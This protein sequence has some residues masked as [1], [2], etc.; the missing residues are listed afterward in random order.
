M[1]S[2]RLS[3]ISP[4]HFF[5]PFKCFSHLF[6]SVAVNHS[7]S[8]LPLFLS[9][10]PLFLLLRRLSLSLWSV[11]GSSCD[12]SVSPWTEVDV[13]FT[14]GGEAHLGFLLTREQWS[15][16]FVCVHVC[17]CLRAFVCAHV[18]DEMNRHLKESVVRLHAG[19]MSAIFIHAGILLMRNRTRQVKKL[20]V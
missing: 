4:L 19:G 18:I 16:L 3:C 12:C 5:F 17:V 15:V 20:G 8:L 7:L 11:T 14:P 6:V 10:S 2:Y 9:F 13:A 1:I